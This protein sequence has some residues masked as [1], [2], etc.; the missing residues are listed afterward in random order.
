[1]V[2]FDKVINAHLPIIVAA[3]KIPMTVY[4][5]R[6]RT[7][8]LPGE[9]DTEPPR[10]YIGW[11][12]NV[13][14]RFREHR[15]EL[16]GKRDRHLGA[17]WTQLYYPTEIIETRIGHLGTETAVTLEYMTMHGIAA[18]RGGAYAAPDLTSDQLAAIAAI[19]PLACPR[20][21]EPHP[22]ALCP[23]PRDPTIRAPYPNPIA[24]SPDPRRDAAAFFD[25]M[26]A[27]KA[28][29]IIAASVIP[30]I[31]RESDP[32]AAARLLAA[33]LYGEPLPPPNDP[34]WRRRIYDQERRRAALAGRIVAPDAAAE[35]AAVTSILARLGATANPDGREWYRTEH[36]LDP[37]ARRILGLFGL[38]VAAAS[39]PSRFTI[40][41]PVDTNQ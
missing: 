24:T 21:P 9:E 6:C 27:T 10:F 15:G 18:V 23:L 40:M 11:S 36:R 5:L 33:E 2:P 30:G 12:N 14:R 32:A 3:I 7:P 26:T 39:H 35:I 20:C 1:M 25:D 13:D 17:A 8:L 31:T 38:V 4:V 29:T 16:R 22:P 34:R 41:R 28:Q 19:L 37:E